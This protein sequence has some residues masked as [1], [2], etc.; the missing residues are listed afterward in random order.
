MILLLNYNISRLNHINSK[1]FSDLPNYIKNFKFSN[2]LQQQPQNASHDSNK[3]KR[4][5]KREK[6]LKI[7]SCN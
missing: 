4:E 7:N 2:L 5:K 3:N 1:H 6:K